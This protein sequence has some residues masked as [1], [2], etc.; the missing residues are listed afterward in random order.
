L[1]KVDL[2]ANSLSDQGLVR[3]AADSRQRTFAAGE[4]LIRQ[5]EM[6]HSMFILV[7]GLVEVMVSM[8]RKPEVRVARLGPGEFFGEMALLTGEARSATIVAAVDTIAF[9]V[10]K[11][12]M[13]DLFEARPEIADTLSVLIA[14]RRVATSK[15]LEG[16]TAADRAEASRTIAQQVLGKI[17]SFFQSVFS[18][19]ENLRVVMP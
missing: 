10:T 3:L 2:F 16:A 8:D 4:A 13:R 5:G 19:A 1:G 11:A 14:G 6:D 7:E 17:K 15:A 9:E 12:H 18:P